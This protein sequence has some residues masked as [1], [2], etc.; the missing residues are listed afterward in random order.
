MLNQPYLQAGIAVVG[1]DYTTV[2][3]DSN[4][5]TG[6]FWDVYIGRD[7]GGYA[8]LL[9]SLVWSCI[10]LTVSRGPDCMGMGFPPHAGCIK[11]DGSRD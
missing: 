3:A 6:A 4:S 9:E 5:K 2:A 7:I 8:L 1:F 11:H 10:D